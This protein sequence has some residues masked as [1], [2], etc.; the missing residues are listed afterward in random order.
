[1]HALYLELLQGVVFKFE[2]RAACR[3]LQGWEFCFSQGSGEVAFH[4]IVAHD[5]IEMLTKMKLKNKFKHFMAWKL[6]K[7]GALVGKAPG[8]GVVDV[9][10]VLIP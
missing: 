10:R 6:C 9:Q 4:K 1:M 5:F 8:I 2:F 3:L 7:R